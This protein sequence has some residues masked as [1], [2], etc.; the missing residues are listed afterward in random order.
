VR[1]VEVLTGMGG[2]DCGIP[3]RAGDRYLVAASVDKDGLLHAGICSSTRR[4]QAADVAIRI[5][6]QRRDGQQV[7]S[8]AGR[9][10]RHERNFKGLL[11]QHEPQPL[12]NALIRLK[13]DGRAFEA[14]ADA[15]GLYAFYNL[16]AGR[17]EF[18]PDLPPGTTLSWFIGSDLPLVPFELTANSCQE[19]DIEVFASGSIRG[20]VLDSANRVLPHAFVYIVPA[21]NKQVP[22][23]K[24]LYWESQG[25]EKSFKFVH[26]PPGDYLLV[27]NPDDSQTPEFPYGRTFYPGVRDRALATIITVREGQQITDADIRLERQF[28][29]RPLKVRVTWADGRLIKDH[30]FITATGTFNSA[31]TAHT[32]QPNPRMSIV[33]VSLVPNEP[34][35]IQAE[36]ICR[37]ADESSVG[38]GQILK[39]NQAHFSA[40]DDRKELHLVISA[41]SCP[42]IAGKTLLTEQ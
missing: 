1:E 28:A 33:D 9:I 32:S 2:G 11:G 34:Y 42:N 15:Q 19:R 10:A 8:L 37:Y 18:V 6:R 25:K 5:L 35:E 16:P 23:E 39:S 4:V 22:P 38:P 21:G 36:L 41:A 40:R 12:S 7:P 14:R 3:F 20:R 30:E 27:V 17:Y 31:A 24:E 29:P 13:A 26:V